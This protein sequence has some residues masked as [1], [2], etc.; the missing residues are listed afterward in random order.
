MRS[1]FEAPEPKAPQSSA[2]AKLLRWKADML[3]APRFDLD[4]TGGGPPQ[5]LAVDPRDAQVAELYRHVADLLDRNLETEKRIKRRDWLLLT[6]A[7][8]IAARVAQQVLA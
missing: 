2:A 4:H 6:L 8:A 5:V 3:E 1:P 7:L